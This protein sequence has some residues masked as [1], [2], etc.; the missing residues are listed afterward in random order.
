MVYQMDKETK[1]RNIVAIILIGFVA[2][3]FFHYLKGVYLNLPYPH[4]TFLF[5][6]DDKFADF[7]VLYDIMEYRS[8]YIGDHLSAQFPF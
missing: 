7:F 5:R 6:P 3:L 8:P 2:S 1:I 4:N